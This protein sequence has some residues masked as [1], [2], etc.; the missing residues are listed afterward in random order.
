MNV[1]ARSPAGMCAGR[2]RSNLATERKEI[3]EYS[4][5]QI[6]GSL[7]DC[8]V[9]TARGPRFVPRNDGS[10]GEGGERLL[11]Y[12]S[13]TIFCTLRK[14]CGEVVVMKYI[15]DGK[16]PTG[17]DCVPLA[18]VPFVTTRPVTPVSI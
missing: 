11:S 7:R 6:P 13:L 18:M 14:P 4:N 15:P 12:Y 16:C 8:F 1:I 17:I 5:L 2:R 9:T 3:A 10:V